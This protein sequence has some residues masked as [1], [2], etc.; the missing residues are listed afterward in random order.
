MNNW[1]DVETALP[2][3]QERVLIAY[4]T[5]YGSRR[6]TVGWHCK[7]R[8]LESSGFDGEVDEEYDEDA[9][10]YYMKEQWVDESVESEYHYPIS[11][12]THWM[13]MPTLPEAQPAPSGPASIAT[14]QAPSE[15]YDGSAPLP[16]Q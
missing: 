4:T 3:T 7:A 14:E 1:V 5:H 13:P 10:V 15:I 8:T 11:G 2:R 12:V 9:D 6:V 16:K